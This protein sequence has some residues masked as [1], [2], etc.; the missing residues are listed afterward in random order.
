SSLPVAA[1]GGP[2]GRRILPSISHIM[3][4]PPLSQSLALIDTIPQIFL[5]PQISNSV[6]SQVQ[7]P[8]QAPE[9]ETFL[10][11]PEIRGSLS[12]F[13]D[14]L[15]KS[16]A[17]NEAVK[18]LE[19]GEITETVEIIPT[20]HT[21][22]QVNG[23]IGNN[24]E[25]I[26]CSNSNRQ[27]EPPLG[28]IMVNSSD[29]IGSNG[30]SCSLKSVLPSPETSSPKSSPTA[31]KIAL[32]TPQHPNGPHDQVGLVQSQD[33]VLGQS[34]FLGHNKYGPSTDHNFTNN[35]LNPG[36]SPQ[37]NF[38]LQPIISYSPA[39]GLPLYGPANP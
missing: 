8:F 19:D 33:Q 26:H 7:I 13:I 32:L 24:P 28:P 15:K 6:I 39:L 5:D 11:Q 3:D 31:A 23:K 34:L 25:Q 30:L 35:S 20:V 17:E 14:N 12:A 18:N 29:K 38:N 36:T 4:P 10:A 16:K 27:T 37:P 2:T 9:L 22:K 21:Q 1:T